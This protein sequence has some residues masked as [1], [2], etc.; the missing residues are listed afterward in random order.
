MGL[1]MEHD[2][3]DQFGYQR[4]GSYEPSPREIAEVCQAVR[5]G[6]S[7]WEHHRRRIDMPGRRVFER[8][9]DWTSWTVP[10]IR[11]T[12]EIAAAI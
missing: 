7:Q 11:V 3:P 1:I 5:R 6:W 4:D 12:Q 2:M 8:Q 10:T 9:V